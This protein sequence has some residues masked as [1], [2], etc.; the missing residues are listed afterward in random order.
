MNMSNL[1][2]EFFGSENRKKKKTKTI[3]KKTVEKTSCI[4]TLIRVICTVY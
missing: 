3:L 2:T 4:S 1:E